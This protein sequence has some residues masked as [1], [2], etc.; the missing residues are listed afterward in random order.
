ARARTT[1]IRL[2][3][4]ELEDADWFTP[5]QLRQAGEWGESEVLCLPRPDS[6]ARYLIERW[7]NKH[8]R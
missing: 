2:E 8:P 5:E 6:I 1:I 4:D 7:L 3:D